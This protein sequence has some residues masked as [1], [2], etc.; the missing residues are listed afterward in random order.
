MDLQYSTREHTTA[1][2]SWL[3]NL[4]QMGQTHSATVLLSAATKA[5]HYPNGRIKPGTI[6]A[7]FTSGGNAGLWAPYVNDD[8]AGEGLG[9]PAGIVVDG[10]SVRTED[11]TELATKTAGSIL[12]AGT[13]Q[14]VYVS[15]LPGLL[16]EDGT[17]AHPVVVGDL[18]A[19]FVNIDGV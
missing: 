4:T 7:Q 15:K 2:L 11:G 1:D 13:P 17:T 9:T 14:Q 6:L 19:S 12:L 16:D 8:T 3:G 10:F 18:P 5:T